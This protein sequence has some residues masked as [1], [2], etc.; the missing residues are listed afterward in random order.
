MKSIGKYKRRY[1]YYPSCVATVRIYCAREN[2]RSLKAL[3]IE[4]IGRQLGRPSKTG[5][6]KLDLGD[7]I[8]YKGNLVRVKQDTDW[9]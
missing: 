5:K 9:D 6:V 2:R 4:L 3:G 7:A 8:Q 1:G